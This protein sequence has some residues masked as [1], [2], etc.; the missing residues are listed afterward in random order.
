MDPGDTREGKARLLI[1]L[2]LNHVKALPAH[3][4]NQTI[5]RCSVVHSLHEANVDT[6]GGGGRHNIVRSGANTGAG[7]TAHI[8]GR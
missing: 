4:L 6:G 2:G 5:H 3:V 7:Q 1:R 8:E